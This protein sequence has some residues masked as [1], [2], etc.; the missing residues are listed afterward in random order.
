VLGGSSFISEVAMSAAC[1]DDDKLR[2]CE[3][4]QAY[5]YAQWVT[6]ECDDAWRTVMTCAAGASYDMQQCSSAD[7]G[8]SGAMMPCQ[9]E[10]TA[11]NDCFSTHAAPDTATGSR[12]TC[13]FGGGAVSACDVTCSIGANNFGLQCGGPAGLPLRCECLINGISTGDFDFGAAS[14]VI[15]A[16]DCAAAAQLAA[17]GTCTN[18]L[19]CCVHYVDNGKDQ[20]ICGSD[21]STFGYA[22]CDALAAGVSGEVVSICPRY[23]PPPPSGCWP[24]PCA[25]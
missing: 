16:N 14:P 17:N 7:F 8:S 22:T 3:L 4:D 19:D 10:K 21:P 11:L 1:T 25:Q 23:Q 2:A 12:G 24:P 15:Y 9:A 5:E 18:R 20:C 6:P 13:Y